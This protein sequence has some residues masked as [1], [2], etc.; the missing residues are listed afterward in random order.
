MTT[1]TGF[2]VLDITSTQTIKILQ[3]VQISSS[4]ILIL[5]AGFTPDK[6][7]AIIPIKD[8]PNRGFSV[9]DI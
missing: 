6:R 3:N 2:L 5:R 1:A 7:F 8:G 9:Y 4:T